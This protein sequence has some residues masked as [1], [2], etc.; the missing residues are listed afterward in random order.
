MDTFVPRWDYANR[1]RRE[2]FHVEMVEI[3]EGLVAFAIQVFRRICLLNFILFEYV[4]VPFCG[5]NNG[6]KNNYPRSILS[7][8]YYNCS[9]N[10][11]FFIFRLFFA[12]DS[13]LRLFLAKKRIRSQKSKIEFNFWWLSDIR[14]FIIR[15]DCNAV[16]NNVRNNC[17]SVQGENNIGFA[18]GKSNLLWCLSKISTCPALKSFKLCVLLYFKIVTSASAFS[19]IDIHLRLLTFISK[20]KEI[21]LA[22]R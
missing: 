21:F 15:F 1:Y 17:T 7:L 14:N 8:R 4:W 12:G 9:L 2:R 13:L 16:A 3:Y 11:S 18:S 5:E 22:D 6:I 19:F 20:L 10:N